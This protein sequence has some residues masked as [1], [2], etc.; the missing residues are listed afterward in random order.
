M[1]FSYAWS[2]TRPK[3]GNYYLWFTYCSNCVSQLSYFSF[4]HTEILEA[5][6]RKLMEMLYQTNSILYWC[7][8]IHFPVCRLGTGHEAM[9]CRKVPSFLPSKF[10]L[11]YNHYKKPTL[12]HIRTGTKQGYADKGMLFLENIRTE[13]DFFGGIMF[14]FT[15]SVLEYSVF[16]HPESVTPPGLDVARAKDSA[17]CQQICMDHPKSS[18]KSLMLRLYWGRL[19]ETQKILEGRGF[20][21]RQWLVSS[22]C[23]WRQVIRWKHFIW[24]VGLS[25]DT[26]NSYGQMFSL[27]ICALPFWVIG[28]TCMGEAGSHIHEVPRPQKAQRRK[29]YEWD[30]G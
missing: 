23:N 7:Y 27:H 20:Q 3:S 18:F 25:L 5:I 6:Y 17:V 15:K 19:H 28:C 26:G 4:S 21:K 10:T 8:D 24:E 11:L 14:C 12:D 22:S 30:D 1:H 16:P 9:E 29:Y 13:T 2:H